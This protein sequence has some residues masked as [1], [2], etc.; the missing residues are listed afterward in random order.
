[1]STSPAGTTCTHG[2]VAPSASIL[3]LPDSQA[4]LGR[5]RCAVCAYRQGLV[6]GSENKDLGGHATSTCAHGHVAPSGII[7]GLDAS[8]AGVGRHK[9]VICAYSAGYAAGALE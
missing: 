7:S 4:G 2:H 3:N 1:M 9:C 5:H 8:Q 6:D